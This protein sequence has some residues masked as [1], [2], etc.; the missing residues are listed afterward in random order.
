MPKKEIMKVK[1]QHSKPKKRKGAGGN[2]SRSE[3]ITVRLDPKLKFAAELA[4]RKHRRT[5][6]SFIEWAI[7]EALDNVVL[8]SE[9]QVTVR[10]ALKDIWDPDE[11]DRFVM[12][13][14]KYPELLNHEEER[15]WKC[16]RS[17]QH[18]WMLRK[19]YDKGLNVEKNPRE[20]SLAVLQKH[21]KDF[22]LMAYGEYGDGEDLFM[23]ILNQTR[24][25]IEGTL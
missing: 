21:F 20:I 6:S 10:Q 12:Q 15:L 9:S 2:L 23:N 7:G 16:I 18:V 13:A 25:R 11:A 5:L 1:K 14:A 19:Q 4:S 24:E 3:V 8:D 17:Y 22:K